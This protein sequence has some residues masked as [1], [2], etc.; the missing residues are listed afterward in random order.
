M[1]RRTTATI[2]Y[3]LR[4]NSLSHHNPHLVRLAVIRQRNL[5]AGQWASIQHNLLNTLI[6][7]LRVLHAYFV[8]C[9]SKAVIDFESRPIVGDA[10][11]DIKCIAHSR[12]AQDGFEAQ[13]VHPGG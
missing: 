9:A 7:T 4:R 12:D 5:A 3:T 2:I 10:G 13:S 11:L 6:D 8:M 1:V